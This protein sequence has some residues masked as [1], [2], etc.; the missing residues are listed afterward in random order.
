VRIASLSPAATEILFALKQENQIVVRD[1]FSNFPAETKAIPALRG[2]QNIDLA[3]LQSY[4]PDLVFTSTIIQKKLA[5][6][7]RSLGIECIHQDPRSL[8]DVYQS[9]L[10]V[11]MLLDCDATARAFTEKMRSDMNTVKK[12][13]RA[14]P[15][16]PRVYI[17]EWP[18]LQDSSGKLNPPMVSGN[19]VP[20]VLR[21]AGGRELPGTSREL[22]REVTLEEITL[23]DP[24]MIVLSICGAG[25]TAEKFLITSR[26]GWE[27]ITAVKEGNIFVIDD[28]L[29]NRPGLRLIEGAQRLYAWMFEMLH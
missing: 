1:Q 22:S 13:A 4:K 11:G 15:H 6:E 25:T 7:I 23:F 21:I 14:L 26:A 12:R 19:W 16:K 24:E 5:E 29:L 8:N 10:E 28:S 27:G 2:H 3:Q 18:A 20:E 9:I 17:E